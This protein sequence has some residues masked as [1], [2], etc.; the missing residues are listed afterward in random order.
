MVPSEHIN[1]QPVRG[2]MLR[3]SLGWY[4]PVRAGGWRQWLI[5]SKSDYYPAPGATYQRDF[6]LLGFAI[7]VEFGW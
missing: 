3:L 4:S 7:C 1:I 2:K 6:C 5:D